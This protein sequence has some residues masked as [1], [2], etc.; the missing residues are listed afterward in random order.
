MATWRE[1][2]KNAMLRHNETFDDI[3]FKIGSEENWLDFN[4]DNSYGSVKGPTFTVWTNNRVY[5]P[6]QYDGSEWCDSVARHPDDKVTTHIGG[7]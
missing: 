5:F 1:L 4:F 6:A 7:G 3:I 2:I